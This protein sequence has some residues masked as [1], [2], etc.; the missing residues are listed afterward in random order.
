MNNFFDIKRFWKYI[1]YDVRRARNNYWLSLL[2][3]GLVPI[4]VFVLQQCFAQLFNGDWG[5]GN[6]GIQIGAYFTALIVIVISFP[7]KVYGS[8]TQKRAGSEWICIPASGFEKFLSMILVTCVLLPACFGFLFFGSDALL[9]ATVPFYGKPLASYI[10]DLNTKLLEETDGILQIKIIPML[11]LSWCSSILCFTLGAT[12][13]KRSKAAKTILVT[14][15]ISIIFSFIS[16]AVM[17]QTSFTID[18]F[19]DIS[20]ME[21]FARGINLYVNITSVIT[22]TLLLGGLYA[23]IKTIKH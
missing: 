13:F 7:T 11:Y 12:F 2:I 18:D 4:I 21:S 3:I 16:T 9:S 14:F 19:T 22:F 5:E 15:A 10:T 6:I 20:D 1:C 8:I 17:G 23:R